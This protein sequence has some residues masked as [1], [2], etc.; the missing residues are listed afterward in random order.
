MKLSI[1]NPITII[2]WL[3]ILKFSSSQS[4]DIHTTIYSDCGNL[5]K[6]CV[7][8]EE[9]C[10]EDQ[11]CRSVGTIQRRGNKFI[12][13][14]QSMRT[15]Q[16]VALGL[17]TDKKMSDDFAVECVKEGNEIKIFSSITEII[18]GSYGARRTGVPQ[19]KAKLVNAY[20]KDNQIFCRVELESDIKFDIYTFNLLK[21][22]YHVMVVSGDTQEGNQLGYHVIK[23]V[24]D[25][26]IKF[27]ELKDDNKTQLKSNTQNKIT[28]EKKNDDEIYH[29]C[30]VSKTCFGM[31]NNCVENN[32]CMSF[33]SITKIDGKFIFEMKS[34]KKAS[35]IALALSHDHKMGDDSVMECVKDKNDVKLFNSLTTDKP[36]FE[37]RRNA[38]PQ[39]ITNLITSSI[40]NDIIYCRF[41][42]SSDMKIDDNLNFNLND[43]SYYLMIAT[44]NSLNDDSLAQ[45]TDRAVS[46]HPINFNNFENISE[47]PKT[48]INLHASLMIV[49]WLGVSAVSGLLPRYYKKNWLKKSIFKKDLWFAFHVGLMY[50]TLILTLIGS[51]IIYIELDGISVTLNPHWI[52]GIV[53]ILLMISQVV[54]ALFRPSPLSKYRSFFNTAHWVLG[55]CAQTTATCAVYL[56]VTL[57]KSG[58][59]NE[60]IFYFLI[61]S[62]Y[63]IAFY[64]VMYILEYKQ[65]NH[66]YQ[67]PSDIGNKQSEELQQKTNNRNRNNKFAKI[68]TFL[69]FIFVGI[70][71]VY[72]IGALLLIWTSK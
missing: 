51:I 25:E 34:K 46:N 37:S 39:N 24:S 71:L 36:P 17:S 70:T 19:D 57:E 9:G 62:L 69:F 33:G 15:F 49:A 12:F 21:N 22:N 10:V 68:R 72:L 65:K 1:L 29:G 63:Y 56:S 28:A 41:E 3:S 35:Y 40:N 11:N 53:T 14:M 47:R 23:V 16:Y 42:R 61:F 55:N 64:V 32:D 8:D 30:G 7:G 18:S 52:F 20:I 31:P 44:G 27:S 5:T 50:L 67:L 43:E 66:V 60:T 4:D 48:F 38:V 6:I 45:H 59:E 13:E 26:K 54:Y 58:L 2:I